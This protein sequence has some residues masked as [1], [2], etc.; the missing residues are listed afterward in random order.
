MKEKPVAG[1][2]NYCCYGEHELSSWSYQLRC[3]GQSGSYYTEDI[4]VK[5]KIVGREEVNGDMIKLPEK[6]RNGRKE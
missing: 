5:V 4:D 3:V 1:R 6:N 2:L